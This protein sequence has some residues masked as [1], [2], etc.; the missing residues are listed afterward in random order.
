MG[1]LKLHNFRRYSMEKK[2]AE[3]LIYDGK[4][5]VLMQMEDSVRKRPTRYGIG[6]ILKGWNGSIQ[7]LYHF[8]NGYGAS[9]VKGELISFDMW[10]IA[11]IG[12]NE[13]GDWSLMSDPIRLADYE[14]VNSKLAFIKSLP[15]GEDSRELVLNMLREDY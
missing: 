6:D 4:H 12:F 8:P 11:V 14:A 10:E 2:F 3:Y 5:P 7:H 1:L 13:E 15:A 9:V